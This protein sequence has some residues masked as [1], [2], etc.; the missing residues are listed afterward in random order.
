M[1]RTTPLAPS[2]V[3]PVAAVPLAHAAEET[4]LVG[5]CISKGQGPDGAPNAPAHGPS[6]VP[7]SDAR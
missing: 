4:P 6:R 1:L 5:V 2:I 3:V 7:V